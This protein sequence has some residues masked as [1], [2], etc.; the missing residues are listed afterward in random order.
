MQKLVFEATI[1]LEPTNKFD[2]Q[3]TAKL[4]LFLLA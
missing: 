2:A 4:H 1:Y 3:K